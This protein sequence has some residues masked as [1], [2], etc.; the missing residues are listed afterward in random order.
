VEHEGPIYVL[1]H[2]IHISSFEQKNLRKML[3]RHAVLYCG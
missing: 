1:N 2:D 3:E